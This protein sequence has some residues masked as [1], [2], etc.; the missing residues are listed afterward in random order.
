MPKTV[1]EEVWS[2]T[3]QEAMPVLLQQVL[4][5]VPVRTTRLLRQQATLPL[6]QQ[7]EDQARWPQM[8]LNEDSSFFIFCFFGLPP[9]I[10]N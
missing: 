4:R 9:L 7:L 2:N 1:C 5:K 6:L 10:P 3:V 8:P